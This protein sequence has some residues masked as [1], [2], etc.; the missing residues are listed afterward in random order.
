M[1]LKIGT[2]CSGIEAPIMALKRLKINFN[3]VWSCDIDENVINSIKANYNPKYIY[4]DIRNKKKY[5]KIDIYVSGF[6]CQT[7]SF[8]GKRQGIKDP[9][10]TIFYECIKTIKYSKPKA[11][12][13]ENVVGLLSDDNK[14]TF[15][16]IIN[17]LKK[18]KLYKIYYNILNSCDYG[19]PQ[20]RK[21]VFIIGIHLNNHKS[22]FKWPKQKKIKNIYN[23]LDKNLPKDNITL[24]E[25]QILKYS[26][27]DFV[28]FIFKNKNNMIY[29]TPTI[30]TTS[31]LYSRK[32]ERYLT[33]KELL[34]LQGFP[35]SFK[36]VVSN[37]EF[38]KQIGNSM[39]VD[40]LMEIFKCLFKHT[41]I[42]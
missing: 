6:P 28:D 22:E 7:F 33:I 20:N 1:V 9:R 29:K 26:K 5:H 12:I 13:L 31:R 36:Q 10:G 11:F 8:L 40:V 39:T 21:R 2:D 4:K 41:N 42:I 14:K 37:N 15:N 18:L 23:I 3:H 24:R 19:I 34:Q 16:T 17:T 25:K 38:K 32:Y 35:K 30:V 27:G